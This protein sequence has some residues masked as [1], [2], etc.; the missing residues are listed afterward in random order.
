MTPAMRTARGYTH[1]LRISLL[2][3]IL[4]STSYAQD[5]RSSAS[6]KNHRWRGLQPI[7]LLAECDFWPSEFSL[8]PVSFAL[9]VDGTVIY[10]QGD[11]LSGHYVSSHLS[12]V[13]VKKLLSIS[14]L[15]HASS[16][17]DFYSIVDVTDMPTNILVVKTA[18][19]YKTVSVYGPL[20]RTIPDL[21][22]KKLPSD[23][24]TA[25]ET[26][27][28]FQVSRATTWQPL[29]F[30]V[31]LGPFA[32]AKSSVKWPTYLPTI[33]DACSVRT[34]DGYN[35]LIP[36]AKFASYKKFAATLQPKQA[37]EIDGMKWAI[38]ARFPLPHE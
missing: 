20:R 35:L 17:N 1:Y 14:H 18:N 37:V 30:E 6:I 4:V 19:G 10:W 5:H 27:F 13:E 8:N 33:S 38:S 7:I 15:D 16:F 26:L 25:F 3:A 28:A 29:F 36:I 23:L 34:K 2:L 32:H 9:Y 22:E 12:K 31:I 21:P 24:Q 11:S